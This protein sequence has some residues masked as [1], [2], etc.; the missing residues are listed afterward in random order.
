MLYDGTEESMST[1][2]SMTTLDPRFW[3]SRGKSDPQAPQVCAHV[4]LCACECEPG[5][6]DPCA[7]VHSSVFGR[8]LA[9]T[10]TH[11][12]KYTHTHTHT[13]TASLKG[14]PRTPAFPALDHGHACAVE[15]TELLVSRHHSLGVTASVC[16]VEHQHKGLRTS[17]HMF[18]GSRTTVFVYARRSAHRAS[19]PSSKTVPAL[20]PSKMGLV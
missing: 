7:T 11:T 4:I 2:V 12:H 3:S 1:P 9:R 15:L 18:L 16:W 8:T 14:P 19:C 13:H 5:Y 17:Q 20:M 10:H 6:I